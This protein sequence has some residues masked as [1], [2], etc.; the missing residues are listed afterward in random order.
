MLQ[1][2]SFSDFW[3]ILSELCQNFVRT[4][5][6]T[7]SFKNNDFIDL[8]ECQS[9]R[10]GREKNDRVFLKKNLTPILNVLYIVHN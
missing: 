2:I 4:K 9:V 1:N 6:N 3:L 7:F 8:S 10:P 5:K